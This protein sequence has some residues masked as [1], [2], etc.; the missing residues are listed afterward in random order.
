M[1]LH[2]NVKLMEVL[3]ADRC[4]TLGELIRAA[5]AEELSL[6]A[7][8]DVAQTSRSFALA[9]R[10]LE[11]AGVAA[12]AP[13]YGFWVP[14][15]VEVAGKHTDYAGGR[16]L[17]CAVTRGFYAVSA[18]RDDALFRVHVSFGLSGAQA[19][20]TLQLHPE[21]APS[22]EAEASGAAVQEWVKYP[23]AVARRL[24]RNWGPLL[25]VELALECDLPED[26]GLSSSSAMIT[27]SFLALATRNRLASRP[28]FPSLLPTDERLCHYLGCIENGHDCGP[29]LPGAQ[30]VGTFGGSEVPLFH[31][32]PPL[33][34]SLSPPPVSP[35]LSPPSP[36]IRDVRFSFLRSLR[37]DRPLSLAL[38]AP[39]RRGAAHPRSWI[40]TRAS[41]RAQFPL[42]PCLSPGASQSPLS[43]PRR[44]GPHCDCMLPSVRTAAVLFL[45][46]TTR[47]DGGLP[48]RPPP[49]YSR[50]GCG[51]AQGRRADGRL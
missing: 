33:S 1:R 10:R 27:L 5:D 40:L 48:R 44:P 46:H 24:T 14:G 51:S 41:P 47:G 39:G 21:P 34:P 36:D 7:G 29:E 25:G 43:L 8:L 38:V 49:N 32:P 4:R 20:A 18:E 9:A 30:G 31:S 26:S 50:V 13:A 19:D 28:A 3:H 2:V 15:R 11:G 23:A 12:S 37:G 22:G 16:S 45:P 35:S 6:P 42:P 17:L